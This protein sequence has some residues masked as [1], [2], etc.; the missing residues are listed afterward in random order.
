MPDHAFNLVQYSIVISRCISSFI[1]R[2]RNLWQIHDFGHDRNGYT[3][4]KAWGRNYK[5]G[6]GLSMI[7]V[8][9]SIREVFLNILSPLRA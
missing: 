5:V 2:W 4:F 3:T 8:I 6:K 9:M 1:Y 7:F